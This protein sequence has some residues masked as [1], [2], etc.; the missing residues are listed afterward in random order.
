MLG[1]R[2]PGHDDMYFLLEV[3]FQIRQHLENSGPAV[4]HFINAEGLSVIRI[5]QL[6]LLSNHS[7][8]HGPDPLPWFKRHLLSSV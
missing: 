2:A 7:S 3:G 1:L 8:V 5:T 4:I 6:S